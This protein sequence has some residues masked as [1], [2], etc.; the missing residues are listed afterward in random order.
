MSKSTQTRAV[1]IIT[2]MAHPY[3]CFSHYGVMS[4][5][6]ARVTCKTSYFGFPS[7]YLCIS[8][9]PAGQ[10]PE[11]DEEV[12]KWSCGV[13]CSY[14]K[15]S[16]GMCHVHVCDYPD[17]SCLGTF[18]HCHPYFTLQFY[19]KQMFLYLLYTIVFFKYL[20]YGHHTTPIH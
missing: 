1:G 10:L 20:R 14:L 17:Y 6:H 3:A 12:R 18:W 9:S 7:V 11:D 4:C 13:T 2:Y 19:I 16:I 15:A 5:I 8:L